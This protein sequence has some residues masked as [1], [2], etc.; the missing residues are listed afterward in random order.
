MINKI[1]FYIS[2]FLPCRIIDRDNGT[3]YLERYYIGEFFGETFYLHRFVQSDTGEPLHNHPWRKGF[4]IILTGSYIEEVVNDLATFGCV[5]SIRNV[6][7]VNRVNGNHF[8][9]IMKAKPRTWTLFAHG[10]RSVVNGR[11]KGW[12]FLVRTLTGVEFAP[13]NSSP[14]QTWWVDALKGNRANRAPL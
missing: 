10:P 1:L 13:Y 14:S 3:P 2:G 6:R 11:V 12:G 8:H 7:F 4:S 9:R 5:T